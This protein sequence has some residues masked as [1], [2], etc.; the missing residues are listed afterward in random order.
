MA[1]VRKLLPYLRGI[2]ASAKH[3]LSTSALQGMNNKIKVI[4][5]IADGYRET[6][7]FLLKIKHAF[8]AKWL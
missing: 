5:R 2:L 1:F 3:P 8:P 7:Y 6:Q 4:E